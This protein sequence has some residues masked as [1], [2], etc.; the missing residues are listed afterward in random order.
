[1]LWNHHYPSAY[2]FPKTY[3]Y[4][5]VLCAWC[6]MELGDF[7]SSFTTEECMVHMY[8]VHLHTDHSFKAGSNINMWSCVLGQ[9]PTTCK[10]VLCTHTTIYIV[11]THR[12]SFPPVLLTLWTWNLHLVVTYL[13]TQ[14]SKEKAAPWC[15]WGVT[16]LLGWSRNLGRWVCGSFLLL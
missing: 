5:V 6:C 9:Q 16:C 15:K 11:H 12:L 1:M 2:K 10:G 4:H 3:S 13:L 14:P 8:I 7:V